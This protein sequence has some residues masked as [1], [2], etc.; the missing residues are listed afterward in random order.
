MTPLLTILLAIFVLGF[1]S[2]Y[3]LRALIS[4]SAA[5]TVCNVEPERRDTRGAPD[6]R[7]PGNIQLILA[8]CGDFGIGVALRIF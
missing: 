3:G 4:P 7:F 6:Q 2:G 5:Y 8:F 1:G